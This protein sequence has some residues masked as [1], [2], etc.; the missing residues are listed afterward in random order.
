MTDTQ[1]TNGVRKLKELLLYKVDRTVA[2][3]GL[4]LVALVALYLKQ[5][6]VAMAAVG[7]L[8]VYV[9]AKTSPGSNK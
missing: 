8:G 3:V 5:E 6:N 2:I 9:G 1:P 4:V 7:A